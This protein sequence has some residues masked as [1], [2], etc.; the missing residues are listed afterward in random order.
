MKKLTL[1]D[2]TKEELIQYFFTCKRADKGTFLMW[3]LQKREDELIDEINASIDAS[4]KALEEY[5]RYIRQANNEQ[6]AEK[7]LE[8]LFKANEAYKRYE[9]FNKRCNSIE[10]KL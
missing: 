9:K 2:S 3:L 4:Q 10:K 5:I 1:K 7:K 6:Y 8:L